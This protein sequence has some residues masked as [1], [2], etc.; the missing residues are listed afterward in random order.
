M[1]EDTQVMRHFD[2]YS[3]EFQTD[4][5]GTIIKSPRKFG[6]EVEMINKGVEAIT[7]L[8]LSISS[9]FGVDH[10]GSIEAG[11]GNSGIEIIS[12]IMS[13]LS[14]E[15]CV[16]DLFARINALNFS[17]NASCGLHVHID[18]T[19]FKRGVKIQFVRMD[20]IF[21]E[22]LNTL[23]RRDHI[24]CVNHLLFNEIKKTCG[25]EDTELAQLLLDEFISTNHKSLYLSKTIGVRVPEIRIRPVGIKLGKHNL[26]L[27]YYD[28]AD[29]VEVK[30]KF[31]IQ[32]GSLDP[33]PKDYICVIHE[34]NSLINTKTLLYVYSVFNDVFMSM[35][36]K[37]R[38]NNVYCQNLALSFSPNQIE[39]IRSY[40]ELE[41]M[42]YKT[43]DMMET[44]NRKGNHYDDSRYY[45]VNLHTLFSKYGT[46]EIRSHSATLEPN[47]V[48][49]WV[50]LHQDILDKIVNREITIETLKQGAYIDNVTDKIEFFIN[51]FKFRTSLRKY[52]QKRIA[53]FSNNTK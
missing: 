7:E 34:D 49:Y 21:P 47:K 27:D 31:A 15:N 44:E 48:L 8:S 29:F 39:S 37:S 14:G 17:V 33:K 32:I 53:Y 23:T 26:S 22:I 19:D 1:D 41:T 46:V 43:R 5:A 18:G 13:G 28:Y 3:R 50:A 2:P 12:P 6:I 36:P 24:F 51:V 45:G 10:D 11:R 30:D 25:A 16:K 42:W 40:N 9:A 35:L 52:V 4:D 38:R 20:K